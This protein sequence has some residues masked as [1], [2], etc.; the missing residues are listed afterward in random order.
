VVA[1]V[2]VVTGVAAAGFGVVGAG[3]RRRRVLALIVAAFVAGDGR[4]RGAVGERGARRRR[5]GL[6]LGLALRLAVRRDR[7]DGL[8]VLAALE[9]VVVRDGRDLA[10]GVVVVEVDPSGTVVV[11][12]VGSLETVVLVV[13]SASAPEECDEWPWCAGAPTPRCETASWIGAGSAEAIASPPVA[14]KTAA[15]AAPTLARREDSIRSDLREVVAGVSLPVVRN[16]ARA[17]P[18]VGGL[19]VNATR[20]S[21]TRSASEGSTSRPEPRSR[22]SVASSSSGWG[23]SI[24]NP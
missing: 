15:V 1:R 23:A 6:V 2:A 10:A 12:S 9:P 19:E 18:G 20:R 21:P 11:S 8:A 22:A 5:A 4:G 24:S 3:V 17:A 7:G 13:S 14:A 16:A